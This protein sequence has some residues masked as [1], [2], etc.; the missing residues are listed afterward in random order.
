MEWEELGQILRKRY[1]LSA[2]QI[3]NWDRYVEVQIFFLRLELQ[4]NPP[5][6]ERINLLLTKEVV[7]SLQQKDW[8]SLTKYAGLLDAK[9]LSTMIVALP[10]RYGFPQ[11][12]FAAFKSLLLAHPDN[13]NKLSD[14]DINKLIGYTK[15]PSINKNTTVED[16]E[17]LRY[18]DRK[19]EN[20]V[21]PP[22]KSSTAFQSFK[23]T[24]DKKNHNRPTGTE[25]YIQNS[26]RSLGK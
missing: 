5:C 3:S 4:G 20:S 2:E 19:G 16:S 10:K 13:V 8:D 21:E 22:T 23:E 1:P 17:F 11:A 18:L 26:P 14:D 9:I 7:L 6:K 25:Q 12:N 15:N 24:Y